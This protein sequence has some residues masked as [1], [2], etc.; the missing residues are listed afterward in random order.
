[1]HRLYEDFR[2]RARRFRRTE[3]ARVRSFG[4][5]FE[6]RPPANLAAGLDLMAR[7]AGEWRPFAGGTDLM[8]LLEAGKL[9]HRKFLSIW[10]FAEL[11]G[12]D[13]SSESLSIGA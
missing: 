10:K 7:E 8:V 12:I 13:V 3:A 4:P 11:R 1:M 2:V 9:A 5:S 6:L